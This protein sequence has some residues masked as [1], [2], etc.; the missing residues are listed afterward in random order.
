MAALPRSCRLVEAVF[1]VGRNEGSLPGVKEREELIPQEYVRFIRKP[2]EL[3][4]VA[5]WVKAVE[6]STGLPI[7]GRYKVATLN[8]GLRVVGGRAEERN[9]KERM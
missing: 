6:S 5:V 7:A 9:S 1:T 2:E 4:A 3:T 8:K